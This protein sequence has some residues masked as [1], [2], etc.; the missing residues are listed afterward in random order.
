[1]TYQHG[2]GYSVFEIYLRTRRTKREQLE[3]RFLNPASV[4]FSFAHDLSRDY[5]VTDNLVGRF[6]VSLLSSV[7]TQPNL[8]SLRDLSD[9]DTLTSN[10][11]F[12][13]SSDMMYL[14][15]NAQ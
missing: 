15:A 3:G 8:L 12:A 2:S 13:D 10:S 14:F 1:V 4:G 5:F 7:N 9:V 6:E 11:Y